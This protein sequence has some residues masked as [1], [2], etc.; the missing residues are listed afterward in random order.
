L[1]DGSW[2][3]KLSGDHSRLTAGSN[4]ELDPSKYPWDSAF[5]WGYEKWNDYYNSDPVY[6]AVTKTTD[7]F[8][9]HR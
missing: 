9:S 8:T 7:D 6:F 4:A 5:Q 3:E 2:A 1:K